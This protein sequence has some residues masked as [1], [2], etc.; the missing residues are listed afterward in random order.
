MTG[1]VLRN[2]TFSLTGPQ[3]IRTLEMFNADWTFL[4]SGDFTMER[5]VTT[6]NILEAELKQTII[7]RAQRV[8]LVAGYTKFG[9]ALIAHRTANWNQYT[10]HG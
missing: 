5:G 1:S 7:E 3:V 2:L 8:A 6:S 9:N 4:A 10:D